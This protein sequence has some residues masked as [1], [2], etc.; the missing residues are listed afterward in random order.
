MCSFKPFNCSLFVS[1][2]KRTLAS[3]VTN[4]WHD[5]VSLTLT[6]G[7]SL[8]LSPSILYFRFVRFRFVFIKNFSKNF[9][10]QLARAG[11]GRLGRTERLGRAPALANWNLKFFK[12]FLCVPAWPYRKHFWRV[13]SCPDGPTENIFEGFLV[14]RKRSENDPKRSETVR[15]RP[16]TI[17]NRPKPSE[18]DPKPSETVR[19]SPKTVRNRPKPSEND[20]RTQVFEDTGIG[21][22]HYFIEWIAKLWQFIRWD[23]IGWQFIR[24]FSID[25]MNC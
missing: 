19:N 15:N 22:R 8:N 12:E 4:V 13:F 7:I 24:S 3:P 17:R 16:K 2:K 20:P 14:V 21:W 10:F 23:L 1:R 5:D 18:N 11:A 6:N 25:W 9:K